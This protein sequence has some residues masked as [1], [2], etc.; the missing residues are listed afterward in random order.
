MLIDW[1]RLWKIIQNNC[2]LNEIAIKI[3]GIMYSISLESADF[4]L[5]DSIFERITHIIDIHYNC[6]NPLI[7]PVN[8]FPHEIRQPYHR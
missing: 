2:F 7:L 8:I 5:N 1:H 6:R 4:Q 3:G